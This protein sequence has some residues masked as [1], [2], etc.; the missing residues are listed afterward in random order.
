[1][2]RFVLVLALI[3]PLSAGCILQNL[4]P[5]QQ[6]QD[7][8]FL[9]NDQTRWGRIEL[10]AQQVVPAF[11]ATFVRTRREW[12][13]SIAVADTD[14]SALV[15]APDGD[16]ATSTVEITWYDQATLD[17]RGTVLRQHW[18]KTD[19]GFLLDGESVLSGDETLLASPEDEE[20]SSGDTASR[21]DSPTR[22]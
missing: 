14:V 6:L 21:A 5:T 12:G 1:M 4:A 9:L 20:E 15:I 16:S 3:A 19:A 22:G 2:P 7:R 17:L 11:R 8:M 10:A 13:E 18:A